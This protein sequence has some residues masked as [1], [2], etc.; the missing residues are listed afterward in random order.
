MKKILLPATLSMLLLMGAGCQQLSPK[1][2]E[3]STEVEQKQL[4]VQVDLR[5]GD[6]A[7]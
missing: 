2:T 4:M 3:P 5:M 6:E 1:T 7:P